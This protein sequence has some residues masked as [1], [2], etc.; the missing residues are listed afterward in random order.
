MS[1]KKFNECC[2][3]C[4]LSRGQDP[5]NRI[6]I[7]LQG[8]WILNHYNG[9]EGFLGWLALQPRYHYMGI[10]ELGDDE[11]NTIG[12]NFANIIKCLKNYKEGVFS[13]HE[14]ERVYVIFFGEGCF[15]RPKPSCY[16]MHFHIIPRL[17]CFDDFLREYDSLNNSSINAWNIYKL[18]SLEIFRKKFKEFIGRP[19]DE[20]RRLMMY[21]EKCLNQI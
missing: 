12:N 13:N 11:T 5:K 7:N 4:K 8:D 1:V 6:I 2:N 18:S 15:D 14:I 10:A 20:I 21:M 9:S 16:H 19:E 17:K 3:S